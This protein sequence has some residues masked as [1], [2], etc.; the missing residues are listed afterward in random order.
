MPAS[1]LWR[2]GILAGLLVLPALSFSQE[3]PPRQ[4]P[5]LPTIYGPEVTLPRVAADTRVEGAALLQALRA[6]GLILYMRHA[7]S[8]EPRA[9]CP[10]EPG[11]TDAGLQQVAWVGSAM[12]RLALPIHAVWSSDTCRTLDSARGLGLG[13]PLIQASLRQDWQ[14]GKPYRFEDRF[15]YL[16]QQPAPGGNLLLVAHVQG[17]TERQDSI[18][19]EWAEIVVYRP[20][21]PGRP[22]VIARILPQD[23]TDL[24]RTAGLTP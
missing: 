21:P 4:A 6:G 9:Q 7:Q 8:S 20:R 3:S 11:L 23:W 10:G 15:P 12:R 1:R 24:L 22:S 2:S 5:A 14:R 17:A 19:I 18:L 13:E 16:M